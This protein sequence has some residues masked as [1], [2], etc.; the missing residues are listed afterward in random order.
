[1]PRIYGVTQNSSGRYLIVMRLA[2]NTRDATNWKKIFE[3]ANSLAF[4]LDVIHQEKC[5]HCDLHPG[6]VVFLGGCVSL[7]DLGLSRSVLDIQHETGVYGRLDY[8]PPEAFEK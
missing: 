5:T 4:S 1:M 6:N 2:K 8:F 7:L 3:R